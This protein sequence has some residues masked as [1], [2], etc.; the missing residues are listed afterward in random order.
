NVI[1]IDDKIINKAAQ[2]NSTW[3]VIAKKYTE[4]YLEDIAKLN[5]DRADINPKATEEIE[6]MFDIIKKLIE[7]GVAYISKHGV[8]FS[9]DRFPGY[10]KLSGKHLDE[11]REGARVSVDEEKKSPLDFAL[12]KFAKPGEPS[13]ESPWGAGRPGWHIECSAMS[14]KYLGDTFDIHGGGTDLTFPHHENELAQSEGASGKKFVNYWMHVG[15]MNIEGEKMSKSKGNFI[16]V[17]DIVREFSAEVIRLFILSAHYRGP[18]DFSYDNLNAVKNGYREIYYTFQRLEQAIGA[19]NFDENIINS[20]I[21]S[22]NAG[23][24]NMFTEALDND[25]NTPEAIATIYKVVAQVKAALKNHNIPADKYKEHLAI[26]RYL[27]TKMCVVLKIAPVIIPVDK[28]IIDLVKQL[29]AFRLKKDYKSA[30]DL[31]TQIANSGYLLEFTKTG[32]FIIK[33]MK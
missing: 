31:K 18:L 10:G 24:M 2:E 11:L 9:V 13:W 25:F 4:A 8:Y 28:E 32:T 26:W 22:A 29:D 3:D 27:L 15:F 19:Y 20:N 21:N 6:K 1:D 5:I 12:W 23:F 33:E 14:S 7:N 16:M 17:R 30:D